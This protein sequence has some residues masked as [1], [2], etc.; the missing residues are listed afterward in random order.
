MTRGE[1][2]FSGQ[3]PLQGK[4]RGHAE[5]LPPQVVRC[6]NCHGVGPGKLQLTP[7]LLLEPRQRRG[8]PPSAYDEAKF[9]RM[10]RTGAD[11][12]YVLVDHAMPIFTIP[13]A[14]CNALW[15]YITRKET[16]HAGN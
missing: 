14:D 3:A 10:L 1:A 2:L 4:P 15:S 13:D 7:A 12:V 16:A 11:P 9:C 5:F 6:A 8:G